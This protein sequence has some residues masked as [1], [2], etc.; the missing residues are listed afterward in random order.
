MAWEQKMT[1]CQT[2]VSECLLFSGRENKAKLYERE[3][4][5]ATFLLFWITSSYV[6]NGICFVCFNFNV[7]PGYAW[8]SCLA[9][10]PS[11]PHIVLYIQTYDIRLISVCRAYPDPDSTVN[12]HIIVRNIYLQGPKNNNPF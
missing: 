8:C 11:S 12:P 4:A 9:T 6:V 10:Q 7:A 1:A 5:K 3:I 2:S